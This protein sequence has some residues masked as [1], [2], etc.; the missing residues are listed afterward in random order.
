MA[1]ETV[2][3]ATY[4]PEGAAGFDDIGPF[5]SSTLRNCSNWSRQIDRAVYDSAPF[6]TRAKRYFTDWG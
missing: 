6:V 3:A 2:T 1:A 5:G 4:R